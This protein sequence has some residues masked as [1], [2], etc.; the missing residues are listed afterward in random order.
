MKIYNTLTRKKEEFK[1]IKDK[2]VGIYTC[3][4]T[5]YWFAHIGNMRTYIFEDILKRVLKYDGYK[6]K[7]VMNITDVGHLTSDSDAGEDK[8]EKGAKK[9][10]KTVWEIAE[11]YAD[12]FKKDIK[13]L[14]IIEPDVWVKA[15]DTIQEQIELIKELEK[16]GFTYIIKDGV[17]FNTSKLEKY[18]RLWGEGERKEMKARIEEVKGKKNKTDFALWKFSPKDEKRQMEWDS[19]WGVGF[20]GWHTECVAIGVKNLGVP[21]DIHCGGIDHVFIHHTNEIAQAEAAYDKQLANYWMHGEFLNLKE[22]KMS[23]SLGNIVTLQ[24]L[25]QKG[26]SPLAY[27][28]LCFGTHYRSKLY[29]SDESIDFAQNTLNRLYEKVA[30]L[31]NSEKKPHSSKFE[32]YQEKFK[33]YIND[34]LNMP[35]VLAMIWDLIK[36]KN[37]DDSEKYDLLINFDEVLGLGLKDIKIDKNDKNS[38]YIVKT[39]KDGIPVWTSDTSIVP[40]E[41]MALVKQREDSRNNKE[42]DKADEARKGIEGMGWQ[43]EDSG[44]K[45]IIKNNP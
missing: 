26:I 9:E 21:F 36:D 14:H 4:P 30:E 6:V 42:W 7:H 41:V 39:T 38:K 15:T 25:N 20:P 12:F 11:F 44:E 29:F 19:P 22:G 28:Y 33:E 2:E 23:K 27:R 40:K 24:T 37:I 17:Y 8:L 3:G 5:V 45:T 34:D 43:I 13:S 18:G 10:R 1:P 31:S 35:S 16:K 32:E